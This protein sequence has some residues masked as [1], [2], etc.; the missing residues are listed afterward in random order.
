MFK[1]I[2]IMNVSYIVYYLLM[3]NSNFIRLFL[4]C[5][6]YQFFNLFARY[7]LFFE[8]IHAN[9]L[10]SFSFV[11]QTIHYNSVDHIINV[12]R[13]FID[14]IIVEFIYFFF[15]IVRDDRCKWF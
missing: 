2:E 15:R 14:L 6:N 5:K 13:G 4:L 1:T 12:F 9:D 11:I 10:S 7:L 8:F 3:M